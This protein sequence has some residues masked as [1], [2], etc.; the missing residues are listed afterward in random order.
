MSNICIIMKKFWLKLKLVP[1]IIKDKFNIVINYFDEFPEKTNKC[2]NLSNTDINVR[3][4]KKG[5]K[6]KNINTIALLGNFSSGKSS[7]VSSALP[8][9][10]TLYVYPEEKFYECEDNHEPNTIFLQSLIKNDVST[11]SP[12]KDTYKRYNRTKKLI[13]LYII[14]FIIC[15]LLSFII[16]LLFIFFGDTIKSFLAD[17]FDV[18]TKNY[19]FILIP[20]LFCIVTWIIGTFYICNCSVTIQFKG[21]QVKNEEQQSEESEFT[22]IIFHLLRRKI[23]YVVFEDLD[24]RRDEK[25]GF[26]LEIFMLLRDFCLRINTSPQIQR[27]IKFIYC[28]SDKIFNISDER[29]KAFDLIIPV[30]PKLTM[31][32]SYEILKSQDILIE[33]RLKDDT[34]IKL[35]SF[36]SN[37]RLYN[38]IIYEFRIICAQFSEKSNA[39]NDEIFTLCCIKNLYPS[40]FY[41]LAENDNFY[42]NLELELNGNLDNIEKFSSILERGIKDILVGVSSSESQ[43]AYLLFRTCILNGLFTKNYKSIMNISSHFLAENDNNYIKQVFAHEKTDPNL[44]LSNYKIILERIP[45]QYLSNSKYFNISLL[46]YC[47][48]YQNKC[49]SE[50]VESLSGSKENIKNIIKYKDIREDEIICITKFLAANDLYIDTVLESDNDYYINRLLIN[51]LESKRISNYPFNYE[52]DEKIKE[53]YYKKTSYFNALDKRL[54]IYVLKNYDGKFEN[55]SSDC[56]KEEYYE[57]I[58]SKKRYEISTKNLETLLPEFKITPIK[59]INSN[60]A[61]KTYIGKEN[62]IDIIKDYEN[63][64]DDIT[65]VLNVLNIET[66]NFEPLIESK[67]FARFVNTVDIDN[68]HNKY[69]VEKLLRYN[70]LKFSTVNINKCSRFIINCN[71]REYVRFCHILVD[72]IDKQVSNNSMDEIKLNGKFSK[73]MSE[74]I[75]KNLNI[76]KI[77]MLKDYFDSEIF[78]DRNIFEKIDDDIVSIL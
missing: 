60:D 38:S 2:S 77:L 76:N 12:D 71:Q 31:N 39:S 67:Y 11:I 58:I 51:Y 18:N 21:V 33:K 48:K 6:D 22:S 78:D 5:I 45:K 62:K 24:R 35:S 28:F 50:I 55:I 40:I 46:K 9:K 43:N 8:D 63:N 69:I 14:S 10:N 15:L 7:I 34:L 54:A 70:L 42:D 3:R 44:R 1:S 66:I 64:S 73:I 68:I 4:L 23:K 36:I 17:K 72:F 25:K 32:N 57:M 59:C 56:I 74:V 41:K 13:K 49:L 26:T 52:L 20:S 16:C 37:Q 65:D 29:L 53:F 27:P 19:F 47:I 61:V 75:L 30:F